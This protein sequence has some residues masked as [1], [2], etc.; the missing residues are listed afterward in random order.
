ML[1]AGLFEL[2][3]TFFLV[4]CC[5][6][7]LFLDRTKNGNVPS[8]FL[9][10]ACQGIIVGLFSFA[11]SGICK[12][13]LNPICTL[14]LVFNKH[15]NIVEALS[16]IFMQFC[17]AFGG[18]IVVHKLF[19]LITMKDTSFNS[20]FELT[21]TD[22]MVQRIDDNNNYVNS[23]ASTI[24][25]EAFSVFFLVCF[26][27]Y[28]FNTLQREHAARSFALGVGNFIGF[29]ATSVTCGGILS[30]LTIF[31]ASFIHSEATFKGWWV[32]WVGPLAGGALALPFA[33]WLLVCKPFA[34]GFG[35]P[36]SAAEE[37]DPE[38]D[39][40]SGEESLAK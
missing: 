21:Y 40:G 20:A 17:G 3:G 23:Y 11:A 5:S 29:I 12:V 36:I 35:F 30:P 2:T 8:G 25:L 13:T 28:A 32:C 38:I 9:T 34:E 14:V 18:T 16:N 24:A 39:T 19:R 37:R 6:M 22:A 31:P 33:W 10:A 15:L 7:T 4:Y 1:K 26:M 27:V